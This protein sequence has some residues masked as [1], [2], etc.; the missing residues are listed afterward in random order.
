MTDPVANPEP[1]STADLVANPIVDIEPDSVTEPEPEPKPNTGADTIA[2]SE[3]NLVPDR[4]PH[5]ARL[6]VQPH[7][8]HRRRLHRRHRVQPHADTVIH[9]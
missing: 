3:S 4:H 8:R 1:H 2:D 6:R 7:R 9:A 5:L